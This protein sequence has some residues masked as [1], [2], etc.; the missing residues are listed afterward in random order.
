MSG[1]KGSE[2]FDAVVVRNE[3][4]S[5]LT[6]SQCIFEA[7]YEAIDLQTSY[8]PFAAQTLPSALE[9]FLD[10]EHCGCS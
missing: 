9:H 5:G 4:L 1:C 2:T 8:L 10:Q 3:G 7:A 6:G